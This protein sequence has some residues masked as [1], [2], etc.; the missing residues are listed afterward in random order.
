MDINKAF[1]FVPEDQQW[2]SKLLIGVLLSLFSFLIIPALML[3]GYVVKIVRN[4]MGGGWSN[5]PE[6]DDWG[7]LLKDGFLVT[8][9]Q[10][11]YA[12]PFVFLMLAGIVAGGGLAGLAESGDAAGL[13]ATGGFGVM[14]CLAILFLIAFVFIAPAIMVQYALK[15]DL[16]ACFRFGE[17]GNIIRSHTADILIT[18]LVAVVVSIAISVV[19]TVLAL[20]PCLGWIASFLI[21]VAFGPY[22]SYVMAHL[23]GQIA[24]KVLADKAGGPMTGAA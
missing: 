22:L 23:Y 15:D 1:R 5:L 18:F 17:I 10:F 16:G 3:Q 14:A 19:V 6:W 4:V 21:G 13:L 11:I 20:I 9:A 24:G 2:V 7:E 12:L 8:V